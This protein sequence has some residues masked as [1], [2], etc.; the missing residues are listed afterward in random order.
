M[1]IDML[2]G[3]SVTVD[4][5]AVPD[6]AWRRRHATA[7][8]KL[9][10]L[11][12]GRRM[13]REQAIDALWPDLALDAAGPRLHKAAHYARRA[14]G[15]HP[16]AVVLRN[17]QVTLLPEA[18]VVVDVEA[19]RQAAEAAVSDG[20]SDKATD[21]LALYKGPL[22][23]EDVYESWTDAQ[24]QSLETLHGEL[25]RLGGRWDALLREQPA[26]EQ[27]HLALAQ[28]YADRGDARGALRQL[29][30]MEQALRK[31]LGT[32]PSPAAEALR[33]SL[34]G[35]V[36]TRP[37]GRVPAQRQ[38][39]G[40]EAGSDSGPGGGP[41]PGTGSTRLVGRRDIGDL[42]RESLE[43]ADGGRG[44][45][46]LFTG[47]PGV[48]KSS[49]LDL[50]AALAERRGWRVGR[51]TASAVE[52]S[53]PY[54]PVLEALG[55]LCRRHSS[56]LD[57]LDDNFR[58]ELERA[59]S[60]Q[61]VSWSGES[62][63]QRLFV[64]AA[65]LLRLASAGHGLLLVV[66]DIHEADQASLRLLHYLARCA[67]GERAVLA[68]AHRSGGHEG[69]EEMQASLISR[70]IGRRVEVPPLDEAAT[71]RLLGRRFPALEAEAGGRIWAM[72]GGLPFTALELARSTVEGRPDSVAAV[73]PPA[74]QRT[75]Q[76]VAMLGTSFTT[77]EL[78]AVS[79]VPEDEAYRQLE[80]A[81][82]GLVVEP[83]ETGYRFRHALVREGL[84]SGMP[85]HAQ[86]AAR[87]QVAEQLARL[88]AAPARVAHQFIAAGQ[89]MRAIPYVLP[90]VET[91]G[92]LGAYRDALVLVEAVRG[93]ASGPSLGRL[94]ARRG[95]LLMALGDP[96][97]VAAYREAIPVTSGV[98]L[99]LVRARLARAACFAG[100]FEAAA[101]ALDGLEPQGDVADG[102]ILLSRGNL[103]YFTGDIDTAWEAASA[104]RR[105]LLTPED[106]WHYV[107]LVALQGLIAHQRGE[108]FER[109]RLELRQTQGRAG[110]VT[111]LFDAH[112]CVAEYLLYGPVPYAEV[113]EQAENL[114]R[115][116]SHFGAL[117][118]VAFATALIGEAALLMG[119]LD[120]AERELEEAMDLHREADARAGEA[121]NLQRLAE[122]RLAQGRREEADRLLQEAL[123][124]ARWSVMSMH[125]MQRI[126]GTMILAAP[127][128]WA[129]RAVV[130]RAEATLG[131][132]DACPFCAVMIAVPASI[133]CAD[134]G[135]LEEAHRHLATAEE[136]AARWEQSAW[137]AAVLEA[138]AHIALAEGRHRDFEALLAEAHRRF[139]AS[140]QPLDA[141]RCAEALEE[142]AA[143]A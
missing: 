88:G 129:A 42:V 30:R 68:L 101:T 54:A 84:L 46:L 55:D 87:A 11:S 22:L 65:E 44:T 72:S 31:G 66:D 97:A 29:E 16:R 48:G 63:H 115:R 126:Y 77:D 33:R 108:W 28:A 1:R 19:F 105:I 118:G 96:G 18:E 10:A 109:F 113:I 4:G 143:P 69:L 12:R 122:V 53:W 21:A 70:G 114:R 127:D 26:D 40:A 89:P 43:R 20:S 79:G 23:P 90:A 120:R 117:R 32:T 41:E 67:L 119:D 27:A 131:E 71:L 136:S 99:R 92:A 98:D 34:L 25:L 80:V 86:A 15:D 64:A 124:L 138:R 132:T 2:G 104:A 94:L 47:P 24:R 103:A 133:A 102:P 81:L 56:L 9:L 75:F 6:D 17:D 14:L 123:P 93:Y 38:P 45:T 8:V 135:D 52:G 7:L 78:L 110:L 111:A 51:G 59:L 95:D 73:L 82:A 137:D 83:A 116:A 130:D 37:A 91:A 106:P 112:L 100:D 140:G 121:H 50:A 125:L 107:D 49:V 61:D 134:V 60:A 13:H 57:G 5:V 142:T 85:A 74:V 128:R 3:F 36:T 62:A 76:R 141:A 139:S 58:E 39:P 35:A